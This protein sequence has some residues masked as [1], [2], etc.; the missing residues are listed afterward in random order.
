MADAS[1]HIPTLARI[2]RIFRKWIDTGRPGCTD[3][4]DAA[5]LATTRPRLPEYCISEQDNGWIYVIFSQLDKRLYVGQ[6]VQGLPERFW[7][8]A[9]R[10]TD[11][12]GLTELMWTRNGHQDSVAPDLHYA[13]QTNSTRH[14]IRA[15][16]HWWPQYREY[17]GST[18]IVLACMPLFDDA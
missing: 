18:A 15:R 5:A 13:R 3:A 1:R 12:A 10:I 17:T 4:P 14:N 9:R 11:D 16:R 6:T 8:H 2:L 7:Q